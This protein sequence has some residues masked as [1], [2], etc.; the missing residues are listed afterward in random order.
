[1]INRNSK[2][3]ISSFVLINH[4]LS[5]LMV[6]WGIHKVFT[7]GKEKLRL[8]GCVLHASK[9]WMIKS[10]SRRRLNENSLMKS[11]KVAGKDSATLQRK[12]LEKARCRFMFWV[13]EEGPP[14]T[15]KW[16]LLYQYGRLYHLYM[17]SNRKV[18]LSM[19]PKH[20][21]IDMRGKIN[22]ENT[23]VLPWR[24]GE[25]LQTHLSSLPF[26]SL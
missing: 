25:T 24:A 11:R 16:H 3:S 12:V 10:L 1:M 18:L 8:S 21:P 6:F 14:K 2:G 5:L 9:M 26:V 22:R 15:L 4:H 17:S 7:R 23:Y 13:Q 19:W 20:H